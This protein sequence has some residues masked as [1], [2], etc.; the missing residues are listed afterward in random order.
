[1][2]HLMV[3]VVILMTAS[4]RSLKKLWSNSHIHNFVMW[5]NYLMVLVKKEFLTIF[6]DPPIGSFYLHPA[7]IQAYCLA[8]RKL[9][10]KRVDYAVWIKVRRK[11]LNSY[12][13]VWMA[14]VFFIEQPLSDHSQIKEV[15]DQRQL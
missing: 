9:R 2:W 5:L 11:L 12:Y 6:S 1:M 10:C 14:L 13:H 3:Y 7:L 8:M 4:C 15:I